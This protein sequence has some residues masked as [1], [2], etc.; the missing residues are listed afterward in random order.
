MK[1]ERSRSVGA[2][3]A[4][5]LIDLERGQPL[6]MESVFLESLSQA[7]R[8]GVTMPRLEA[9]CRVLADLNPR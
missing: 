6:E 4:S 5:T 3:G 1:I 2:Y 8:A 9:L 7:Q